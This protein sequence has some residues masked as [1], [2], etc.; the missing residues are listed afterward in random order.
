MA[1]ALRTKL[2]PQ[3]QWQRAQRQRSVIAYESRATGFPQFNCASGLPIAMRW[4]LAP[5][6]FER[7]DCLIHSR[8]SSFW[9]VPP[10]D[11]KLLSPAFVIGNEE[12]VHLIE[13][14]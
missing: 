11:L 3:Q 7:C 4:L 6:L 12:L 10:F 1:N 9:P 13:Y 2:R 5:V 14:G 8:S